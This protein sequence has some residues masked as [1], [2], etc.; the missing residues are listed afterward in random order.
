MTTDV[1]SYFYKSKLGDGVFDVSLPVNTVQRV[2]EF[3]DTKRWQ[4]SPPAKFR[5]YH[6]DGLVYE[7][8][9]VCVQKVTTC[10]VTDFTY[11]LNTLQVHTSYQ[12][13]HFHAFPSCG[14]CLRNVVDVMR[15]SYKMSPS[16]SLHVELNRTAFHVHDTERTIRKVFLTSS[17]VESA[18]D[19][20]AMIRAVIFALE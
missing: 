11:E 6:A 17:D 12:K 14:G 8:D 18:T 5:V 7:T 4:R 3:A 13:Q 9:G 10:R 2:I 20:V 19:A 15:V 1:K 16:C